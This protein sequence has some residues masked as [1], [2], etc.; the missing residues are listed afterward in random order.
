MQLS[1]ASH[2]SRSF[3]PSL[4]RQIP[5]GLVLHSESTPVPLIGRCAVLSNAVGLVRLIKGLEI[6]DVDAPVEDTAHGALPVGDG[7][8]GAGGGGAVA[9]AAVG[10]P[11]G[12][13]IPEFGRGGG[14]GDALDALKGLHHVVEVGGGCVADLL[15]LPVGEGVD[16][17]RWMISSARGGV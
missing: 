5:F 10:G 12:F 17:T 15:G 16:Q 11:A 13:A 2:E 6:E 3:F 9:R 7:V 1:N 8:V 14:A 4:A